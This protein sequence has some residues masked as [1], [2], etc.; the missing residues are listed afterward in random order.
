M[1]ME[2]GSTRGWE[3]PNPARATVSGSSLASL[4]SQFS[5]DQEGGEVLI[6]V[7]GSHHRRHK[8]MPTPPDLSPKEIEG[9]ED[10]QVT[11]PETSRNEDAIVVSAEVARERDV[12]ICNGCRFGEAWCR[13]D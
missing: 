3:I 8:T 13:P 10:G 6:T 9:G 1:I 2:D 7:S 4:I 12:S 11:E 5:D